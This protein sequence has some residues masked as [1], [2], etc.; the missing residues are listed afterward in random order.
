LST[1]RLATLDQRH[2]HLHR[3]PLL[4]LAE[5]MTGLDALCRTLGVTPLSRFVDITALEFAE[6]SRLLPDTETL[7]LSPNT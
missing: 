1:L 3:T 5:Y 6:A 2:F 7:F 4:Q